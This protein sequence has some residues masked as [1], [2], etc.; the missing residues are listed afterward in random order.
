MKLYIGVNSD[1][2]CIIS[3]HPLKRFYD[4]DTN[5]EDVISYKDTQ[6]PPHWI[7][8]YKNTDVEIGKYHMAIDEYLTLPA[9]GIKKM[10]N[11]DM[12]WDDEQQIIE[13]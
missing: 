6:L 12:T 11:I 5:R 13:L 4:R 2:T 8:D 10:F 3:R 1:N 7:I 9:D